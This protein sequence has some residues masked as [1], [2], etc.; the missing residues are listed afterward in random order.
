MASTAKSRP[1]DGRATLI[2]EPMS[3]ERNEASAITARITVLSTGA[4]AGPG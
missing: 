3:A 4:L 2:D 1:M